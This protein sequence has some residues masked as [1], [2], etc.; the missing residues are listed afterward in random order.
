MS[1]YLIHVVTIGKKSKSLTDIE[2]LYQSEC[3][4]ESPFVLNTPHML[5]KPTDWQLYLL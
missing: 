5:T 1:Q 3:Q 2:V 4:V